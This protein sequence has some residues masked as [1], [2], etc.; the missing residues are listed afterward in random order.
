MYKLTCFEKQLLEEAYHLISEI[1][2]NSVDNKIS[3]KNFTNR[4][5]TILGKISYLLDNYR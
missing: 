2:W 5:D 3:D 4:V 1:Y